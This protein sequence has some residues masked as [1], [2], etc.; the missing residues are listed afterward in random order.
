MNNYLRSVFAE[1]KKRKRSLFLL[2]H[3]LI[4]ILF[5]VVLSSYVFLRKD[6]QL[7]NDRSI[8]VTFFELLSIGAP[9][10]IAI[11]CGLSAESEKEAGN[12]QNMLVRTETKVITF[13]SQLTML[14]FCFLF[15]TFFSIIIYVVALKYLIGIN[16]VDLGF[17]LTMGVVFTISCSFQYGLS[18]LIS[19]RF[20]MGLNSI[21]G[22]AGLIIAALSPTMLVDKVWPFLPWSWPIRIPMYFFWNKVGIQSNGYFAYSEYNTVITGFCVLIISSI[23]I[24]IIDL[25]WFQNWYGKSTNE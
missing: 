9:L 14:I 24:V 2:L 19:Y 21:I 4:P 10:I 16:I 3:V 5:S 20:G 18:M 25:I 17:Y 12:F 23:S 7:I 6:T 1:F 8:F 13:L 11:I 15:S 22:I